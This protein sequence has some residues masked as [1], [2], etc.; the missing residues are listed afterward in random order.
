MFSSLNFMF[1]NKVKTY[2]PFLR[3]DLFIETAINLLL[4]MTLSAKTENSEVTCRK[5]R[6]MLDAV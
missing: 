1:N 4:L 2:L 5:I 3:V 6:P